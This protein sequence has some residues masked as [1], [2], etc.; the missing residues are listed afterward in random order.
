MTDQQQTEG[1]AP[2]AQAQQDI[3]V[4]GVPHDAMARLAELRPGQPGGIFTS[5]VFIVPR[6]VQAPEASVMDPLGDQL[7]P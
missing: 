3:E 2:G 1:V 4:L 7:S 6:Q 5:G